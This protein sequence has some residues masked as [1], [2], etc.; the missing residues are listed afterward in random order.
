MHELLKP[1]ALRASLLALACVVTACDNRTSTAG[2]STR[3][4]GEGGSTSGTG[5]TSRTSSSAVVGDSGAGDIGT[6]DGGAQMLDAFFGL[7]NAL[8]LMANV[9]CLGATGKDGM[10]VTFSQRV[11][12]TAPAANSFLVTTKSGT[13]HVP[14]CATLRPAIDPS[15]RHTVLLIGQFGDDPSDPPVRVDIVG[16]IPL[17]GGGDAKGLSHAV[18]PLAAGPSLLLGL[19]Y[20]P[21]ALAKTS[22]PAGKTKQIVQITCS[23]GV[24][25]PGGGDLT[26][27]QRQRMH[28]T[29]ARPDGGTYEVTPFAL[30]DLATTTI[31]CSSA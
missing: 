25:A 30:A 7:D 28:V 27:T 12:V 4:G 17:D 26:D 22:C 3:P 11:A 24:T 6:V 8:P 23:G 31:T 29:L 14:M 19:R 9:L 1:R 21:G 20:A 18:T 16:S 5:S 10:P 15:E 2:S 13:T